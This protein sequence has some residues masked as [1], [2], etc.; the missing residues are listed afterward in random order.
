[1]LCI[2]AAQVSYIIINT[3]NVALLGGLVLLLAESMGEA[4]TMFAGVPTMG[5]CAL[6]IRVLTLLHNPSPDS[7]PS[8]TLP[9]PLLTPN[10]L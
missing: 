5:K 8:L 1:M 9:P 2:L 10:P 3:R 7:Q 6:L 4:K